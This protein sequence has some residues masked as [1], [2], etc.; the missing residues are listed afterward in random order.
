MQKG[1]KKMKVCVFFAPLINPS[2]FN[3][4]WKSIIFRYC[5]EASQ[6]LPL[7]RESIMTK[8]RLFFCICGTKC[9]V[10]L[11]YRYDRNHCK[12]FIMFVYSV[13]CQTGLW[14]QPNSCNKW[15]ARSDTRI[16]PWHSPFF[17]NPHPLS[18]GCQI[19]IKHETARQRVENFCK[20]L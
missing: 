12:W 14:Y 10:L 20:M 15:A 1:S 11:T 18:L 19:P 8:K 17:M 4:G 13:E 5:R 9:Q 6:H 3:A 7:H 2:L 16:I